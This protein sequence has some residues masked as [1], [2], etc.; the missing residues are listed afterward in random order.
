[1]KFHEDGRIDL[2]GDLTMQMNFVRLLSA[3]CVEI[4]TGLRHSKGA[5]AK[6]LR[7]ITGAPSRNKA[8]IL[9]HGVLYLYENGGSLTQVWKTVE[10]ALGAERTHKLKEKCDEAEVIYMESLLS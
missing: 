3:V 6:N 5:P 1:M 7:G 10:R 9:E 4:T 2:R 8:D